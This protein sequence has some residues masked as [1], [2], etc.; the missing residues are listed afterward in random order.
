MASW[1]DVWAR[2][3]FCAAVVSYDMA[4][5]NIWWTDGMRSKP[6]NPG[7]AMDFMDAMEAP[8]THGGKRK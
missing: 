3:N 2:A 6:R 5:K 4:T 1:K 7:M 8:K